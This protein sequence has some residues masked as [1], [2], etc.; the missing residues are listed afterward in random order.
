MFNRPCN[1]EPQ[2][3]MHQACN[4]LKHQTYSIQLNHFATQTWS[5]GRVRQCMASC[6]VRSSV[7]SMGEKGVS[8]KNLPGTRA[9]EMW[10]WNMRPFEAYNG[11]L[12]ISEYIQVP[13]QQICSQILE[14]FLESSSG[15]GVTSTLFM[16][17]LCLKPSI[18]LMKYQY[19]RH[20]FHLW[21]TK[22]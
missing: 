10:N 5:T 6:V 13:W 22:T 7:L 20:K 14:F 12:A 4:Q 8:Y 19:Q 1:I 17:H 9:A 2:T 21:M 15:I 3:M 16:L 11:P 18:S